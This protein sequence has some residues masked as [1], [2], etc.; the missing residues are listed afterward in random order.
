[1]RVKDL[2]FPRHAITVRDGKGRKDR[3]TLLPLTCGAALND[4]LEKVRRQHEN[5]LS[6]GLGRAP[7]PNALQRK[8]PNADRQWGWQYVFPASSHYTDPH[9]GIRR[10]SPKSCVEASRG[11]K[12]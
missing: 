7:L 11:R 1:M 2:D 10:S 8:Y 6:N 5:D 12:G 9:T 4:H 3:E